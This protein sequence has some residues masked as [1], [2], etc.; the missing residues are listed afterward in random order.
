M[1]QFHHG[2]SVIMTVLSSLPPAFAILNV[3]L[4][5]GSSGGQ[6]SFCV[7]SHEIANTFQRSFL[8]ALWWF[9]SNALHYLKSANKVHT[10]A[11][12]FGLNKFKWS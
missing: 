2:R 3:L 6:G 11:D 9:L 1:H 8:V 7:Y 12:L 4:A 5:E 10:S